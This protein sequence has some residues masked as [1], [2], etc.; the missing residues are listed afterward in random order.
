MY[1]KSRIDIKIRILICI[2]LAAVVLNIIISNADYIMMTESTYGF[3]YYVSIQTIPNGTQAYKWEFG[4]DYNTTQQQ[5]IYNYIT[6]NYNIEFQVSQGH[7]TVKYNCHSFAW[8]SQSVTNDYWINSPENFMDSSYISSSF[9]DT[10][11][12]GV[13]SGDKVIYYKFKLF[14][15]NYQHSARVY[16]KVLNTYISKWGDYGLYVHNPTE[17]PSSYNASSLRY[18]CD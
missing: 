12:A 13:S 8:Y 16:S 9:S 2:V 6:Y 3:T 7:A 11:P 17:V 1:H 5:E 4:S 10:I 14:S 18:Y 15:T